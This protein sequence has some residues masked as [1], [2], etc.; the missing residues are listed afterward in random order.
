MEVL[1]SKNKQKQTDAQTSAD[2]DE[3]NSFHFWRAP[4]PSIDD[5][6]LE[7]L[8]SSPKRRRRCWFQLFTLIG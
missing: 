6:L 5:S 8:V 1:N 3:F 2:S 7:L 4:P